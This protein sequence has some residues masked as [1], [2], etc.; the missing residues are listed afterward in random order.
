[1]GSVGVVIVVGVR[2]GF[3]VMVV[4]VVFWLLVSLC[5]LMVFRGS[6]MAFSVCKPVAPNSGVHV[7]VR[8]VLAP[9]ARL[10]M[11]FVPRLFVPSN[12]STRMLVAAASPLLV[13]VTFM[14]YGSPV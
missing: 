8:I 10:V 7:Q 12:S 13:I 2:S 5:S 11:V 9:I 1:M 14:G 3:P 6:V 4:V